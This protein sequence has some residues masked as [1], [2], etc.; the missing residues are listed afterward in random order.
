MTAVPPQLTQADIDNAF[1]K[2]NG[3]EL[4]SGLLSRVSMD[5]IEQRVEDE[6]SRMLEKSIGGR[7]PVALDGSG[8]PVIADLDDLW[9]VAS[10]YARSGLVP[11]SFTPKNIQPGSPEF[12]QRLTARIA[13]AISFGKR[14]GM[15]PMTSLRSVYVVNNVPSLWGDAVPG[16][17]RNELRRRDEQ[18]R[19]KIAYSGEGDARKCTVTVVHTARGSEPV[20][21]SETFSMADAK[22][23]GL[24]GKAPWRAS[25]DRM[26]LHRARTYLLRNM[27][28]DIMMSLSVA[29]EQQDF[30]AQVEASKA[31]TAADKLQEASEREKLA[32]SPA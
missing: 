13:I 10:M 9:R 21:Q 25:P 27:F 5:A 7:K 32:S 8:I 28:P 15:D 17:V 29:E 23:A 22:R 16:V 6:L 31:R 14:Y 12:T 30:E 19:E 2:A 18:Y 26:L 20:E 24:D 1:A 3:Q 4:L 11:D